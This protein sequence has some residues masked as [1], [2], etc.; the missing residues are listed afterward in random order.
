MYILNGI[1]SQNMTDQ[2]F[3]YFQQLINR[4]KELDKNNYHLGKYSL[5]NIKEIENNIKFF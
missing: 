1:N 2:V 3:L 5:V 4:Y